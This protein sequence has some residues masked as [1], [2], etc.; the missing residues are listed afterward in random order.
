MSEP[1]LSESEA[2][3]AIAERLLVE[4][5]ISSGICW[6]ACLWMALEAREEEETFAAR[7]TP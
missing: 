1:L 5:T 7:P 6:E 2:F 4:R 3:E